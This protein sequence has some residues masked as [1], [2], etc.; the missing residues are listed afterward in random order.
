MATRRLARGARLSIGASRKDAMRPLYGRMMCSIGVMALLAGSAACRSVQSPTAPSLPQVG[1]PPTPAPPPVTPQGWALVFDDEF[2]V[3]GAPDPARWGH[4]R[5]YVR[6]DEAQYYTSDPNNARVESGQLVIEARKGSGG[7]R[8]T[9]ASL[10][11][12]GRFDLTYGRIEVRAQVP[13]G[14]G[15]WPAIWTLGVTRGW[16][17]GGE[18]DIM[19]YVGFD[20]NSIYGSIHTQATNLTTPFAIANPAGGFHVYTMDWDADRIIIAV[21]GAS[22]V[23]YPNDRTGVGTWPFDAPQYILLSLAIGG[24]WGGQQ[25]IDDSIFPARLLVDYVRV[26]QQR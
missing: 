9:S 26:Y 25:G 14:I 7:R 10:H 21:D 8:Y 5:G 18:V 4:E 16:P 19:E 24:T 3:D 15:T 13:A 2:D 11:T 17:L 1:P 6:N 23:T 22:Y 20:P 12:R